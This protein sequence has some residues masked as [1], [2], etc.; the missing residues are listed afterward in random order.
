MHKHYIRSNFIGTYN[1]PKKESPFICASPQGKSKRLT[2]SIVL[3]G[4]FVFTSEKTEFDE[5][6]IM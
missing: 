6:K 4:W 1:N 5:L 2:K 3:L